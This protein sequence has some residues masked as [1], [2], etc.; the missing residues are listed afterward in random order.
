[1]KVSIGSETEGERWFW[2]WGRTKQDAVRR[3]GNG[4]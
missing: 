2:I 3:G 4:V 1:M